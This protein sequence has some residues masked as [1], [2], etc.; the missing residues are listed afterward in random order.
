MI[1]SKFEILDDKSDFNTRNLRK[2]T[3]KMNRNINKTRK[4]S[5]DKF[6]RAKVD[7]E[8]ILKQKEIEKIKI[9]EKLR[10]EQFEQ[11]LKEKKNKLKEELIKRIHFDEEERTRLE[12]ELADVRKEEVRIVNFLNNEDKHIIKNMNMRDRLNIEEYELNKYY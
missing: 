10:E 1:N 9:M 11:E 6:S 12:H 7:R 4:Y 5:V 3:E 2:N 8:E